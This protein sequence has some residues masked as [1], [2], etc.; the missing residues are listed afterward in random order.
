MAFVP[1]VH[2]QRLRNFCVRPAHLL[3]FC[4]PPTNQRVAARCGVLQECMY[5][6]VCTR[7]R[8]IK[9]Y[10]WLCVPKCKISFFCSDSAPPHP[11]PPAPPVL[12]FS[13]GEPALEADGRTRRA[14]DES[15][16]MGELRPGP[17]QA[18]L[19]SELGNQRAKRAEVKGLH[20]QSRVELGCRQSTK[21]R[22]RP[23]LFVAR[24]FVS[25]YAMASSDR[26]APPL[27]QFQSPWSRCHAYDRNGVN[28]RTVRQEKV[29][30][31]NR[32]ASAKR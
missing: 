24:P 15:H 32:R 8:T 6:Y 10:K 12:V 2:I 9:G 1:S 25:M 23:C 7:V 30:S 13:A 17:Q 28:A 22:D 31:G 5:Q 26:G 21:S 18:S 19:E 14:L 11:A 3:R 29:I 20:L 27:S 16:R 4:R